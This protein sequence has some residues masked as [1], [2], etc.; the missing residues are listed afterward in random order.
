MMIQAIGQ[1]YRF[2]GFVLDVDF[3][4]LERRGEVIV[5]W[6]SATAQPTAKAVTDVT[7][8]VTVMN[9]QVYSVWLAENGGSPTPT[10]KKTAKAIMARDDDLGLV[11]RLLLSML[12]R[13]GV[14]T[15]SEIMAA[16]N[17]AI[18]AGDGDP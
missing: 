16:F 7:S 11:V 8:D 6:T 3:T 1:V 10:R 15:K 4:V 18:D 13:R 17:A 5:N 14:G 9:G 2:L 12:V